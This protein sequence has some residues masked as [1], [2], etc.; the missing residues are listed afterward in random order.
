M[1]DLRR[2]VGDQRLFHVGD[3]RFKQAQ[4][5]YQVEGFERR[6]LFVV[7]YVAGYQLTYSTAQVADRKLYLP[8][9]SLVQQWKG[10]RCEES[11]RPFLLRTPYRRKKLFRG[12]L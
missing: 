7:L 11:I 12:I 5:L 1:L 10:G 9:C 6:V 3:K 4:P 8:P 2:V